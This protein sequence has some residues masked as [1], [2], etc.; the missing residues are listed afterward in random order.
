VAAASPLGASL[1]NSITFAC[2]AIFKK[3][4]RRSL[5]AGHIYKR[6]TVEHPVDVGVR[7]APTVCENSL[8]SLPRCYVLRGAPIWLVV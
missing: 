8:P 2:K 4:L 3:A 5:E 7:D 6:H 1:S